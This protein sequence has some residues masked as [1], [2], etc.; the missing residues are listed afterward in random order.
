LGI[1]RSKAGRSGS[2]LGAHRPSSRATARDYPRRRRPYADD[3]RHHHRHR[4]RPLGRERCRPDWVIDGPGPGENKPPSPLLAVRPEPVLH[5]PG[6]CRLRAGRDC[7]QSSGGPATRAGGPVP[8]GPGPGGYPG[9]RLGALVLGAGMPL[10][11]NL[12]GSRSQCHSSDQGCSLWISGSFVRC[13]DGRPSRNLG[14]ST[15][16]NRR[17]LGSPGCYHRWPGAS[18]ILNSFEIPLNS[19]KFL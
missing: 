19:S 4:A 18:Q 9:C 8:S 11:T 13:G 15:R 3:L 10:P 14:M 2:G 16:T 6:C 17:R 12:N 7:S 1:P 5:V